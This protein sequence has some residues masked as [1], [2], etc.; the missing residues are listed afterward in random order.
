MLSLPEKYKKEANIS[1]IT[2]VRGAML[3]GAKKKQ[4]ETAI[5]YIRLTYQIEGFDIP[6]LVN[7]DYNCQVI[8]FLRIKLKNLR[9][10]PFVASIVQKCIGPLCVI[11][12]TDGVEEQY[13]FADKRLNK[14]NKNSIVIESEF[15]SPKLPLEFQNDDKTLFSL[16]IDY[17]TIMNRSNKHAYYIEMM[18]KAF[19]VSNQNLF[20]SENKLLDNKKLWYD[21]QR[22]KLVLPLLIQLKSLKLSALKA[23]TLVEKS[24]FNKQIKEKIKELEEFAEL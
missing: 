6:N 18:T 3:T 11:E 16:Y 14:Q 9:Q 15:L 19:L 7:D 8:M 4:F 12:I 5:E 21:E 23:K 1:K 22:T 13:S 20:S 24:S 10:A 2:F 17:D